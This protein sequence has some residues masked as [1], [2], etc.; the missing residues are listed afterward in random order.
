VLPLKGGPPR[1]EPDFVPQAML[2]Q[3]VMAHTPAIRLQGF[4]CAPARADLHKPQWAFPGDDF[5][6][7][8]S[9]EELCR[10]AQ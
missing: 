1:F 4:F 5:N 8:I 7:T 9:K 3:Y 6:Q 2:H 10:S